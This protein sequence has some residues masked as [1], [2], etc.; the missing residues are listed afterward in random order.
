[1]ACGHGR[2]HTVVRGCGASAASAHPP[3]AADAGADVRE[4]QHLLTPGACRPRSTARSA[5]RRRARALVGAQQ[6]PPRQRPHDAREA[7]ALRAPSSAASTAGSG[8]GRRRPRRRLRPAGE[9]A[10]IASDGTA[11]APATA[12]EAVKEIIAAGNEI[13]DLPYKYGGGHGTWNDTGY[14]C[15][16]SMSYALHGA[17]LL[18]DALD[19]TGFMSWGKAGRARGSR[20]T[21]TPS[22]SYMVVAGLRFDTSGRAEDGSRWHDRRCA[23]R[24]LH[25]PAPDRSLSRAGPAPRLA[26]GPPRVEQAPCG[27][28]PSA[29]RSPRSPA[30][31]R[32]AADDPADRLALRTPP[33]RAAAAAARGRARRRQAGARPRRPTAATRARLRPVLRGWGE[34]LAPRPQPARRALLRA[35]GDRRAGSAC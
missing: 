3:R 13:H 23:P 18:D 35:A 7:R 11:V 2:R 14:D 8:A 32:R 9:K 10:T 1:M 15:S 20:S 31:G 22:H 16:G 12:P 30:G 33:D 19:S 28:S 24:R 25:R 34:A 29:W 27:A 21:P 5:A 6:R 17:G 4:L 26:P